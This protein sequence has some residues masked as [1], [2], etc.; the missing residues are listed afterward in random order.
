MDS[1]FDELEE[2]VIILQPSCHVGETGRTLLDREKAGN[3]PP[4]P[5]HKHSVFA[6]GDV[7]EDLREMT[8]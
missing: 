2:G 5:G 6:M 3:R 4:S 8:F 7:S 1:L